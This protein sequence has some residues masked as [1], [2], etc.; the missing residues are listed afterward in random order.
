MFVFV[1][2]VVVVV[3]FTMQQSHCLLNIHGHNHPST[4]MATVGRLTVINPGPLVLVI[5]I[6]NACSQL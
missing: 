4:G 1:V 3:F 6:G 5:A 2:V